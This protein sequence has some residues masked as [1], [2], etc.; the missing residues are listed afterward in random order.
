MLGKRFAWIALIVVLV[1]G[2]LASLA[3][4]VAAG[5]PSGTSVP[6]AASRYVVL[7][8]N[9]LGMHE[10]NQDFQDMSLL[11]PG[12]TLWAQVVRVGDP[13]HIMTAGITVTYQMVD[14]SYSVGK[15]NFWTYAQQLF[16][17]ALPVNIGLK[18][19]GLAGMMDPVGDHFMAE[20]IPLTEFRDS[21]PTTPYP[22]Q[23]ATIIVHDAATGAELTR[24][25]VV[26]PV[27]TEMHCDYCHF[28]T[29]FGISTGKTET[30]ILTLHDQR[31]LS[32]Y[33]ANHAG[34]LMGRRPVLCAECHAS[35]AL[36]LP[37]VAGLRS[38]S[39]AMHSR[40]SSAVSSTLDGCYSCHPGPTTR[41]L[42]ESMSS[43]GIDCITCHGDMTQVSQNP[44]PWVNE[45][46]CDSAACH[47]SIQFQQNQPLYRN[48][49]GHGGVYCE[50][51]HDSTHAIAPSTQPNDAIKFIALQ[52]HA[53]TL[54][55]CT[56]CHSTQPTGAGPHGMAA[57]TVI[58]SAT[59]TSTSTPT[60]TTVASPTPTGTPQPAMRVRVRLP[61]VLRH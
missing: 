25:T 56:V 12:N 28:N 40:H 2:A 37:G 3:L 34:P 45:P 52:G 11:P 55:T 47:S 14:N 6:A 43:L 22:Y 51:C 17:V 41:F 7:T 10:Y 32:N 33:P 5:S 1:I 60:A 59:P 57:P 46:R 38:L 20:G 54:N 15:S 19:K 61:L 8:W 9:D 24:A 30:N 4:F 58:P 23:L 49:T 31:N 29:A 53:G 26:A 42:R 35:A 27:S 18:G 16:G 13:P 21:A 44:S 36:A 50:G 48:S 39:A